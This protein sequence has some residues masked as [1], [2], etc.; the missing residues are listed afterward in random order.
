MSSSYV[1]DKT[2]SSE[3]PPGLSTGAKVGVGA[4][5]GVGAVIYLLWKMRSNRR[6]TEGEK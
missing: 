1:P 5:I 6:A 4:D 2:G 3:A